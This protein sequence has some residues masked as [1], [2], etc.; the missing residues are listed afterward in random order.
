MVSIFER[1]LKNNKRVY[2]EFKTIKG[3]GKTISKR[4]C[5]HL[6]YSR[7][8]LMKSVSR[9]DWLKIVKFLGPNFLFGKNLER[10]V[11]AQRRKQIMVRSLKG[12]RYT[13]KLPVNGQ[14]THSNAKT[15][16]R[17]NFKD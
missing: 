7:M 1:N 17:Q 3:I 16:K 13:L 12:I 14:S 5:N 10:Y 2:Y 8:L 15:V 9:K 11:I 6:G 4:L